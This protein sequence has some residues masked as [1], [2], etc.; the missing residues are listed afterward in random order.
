MNGEEVPISRRSLV[1]LAGL[2]DLTE[3]DMDHCQANR[4]D[5]LVAGAAGQLFEN[6][7]RFRRPTRGSQGGGQQT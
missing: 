3:P 2:F 7:L 5:I 1:H 4:R 6:P